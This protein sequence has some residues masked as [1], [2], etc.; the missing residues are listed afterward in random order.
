MET[1]E[2]EFRVILL[3][4]PK[5]ILISF[6]LI[7]SGLLLAFMPGLFIIKNKEM[8]YYYLNNFALEIAVGIVLAGIGIFTLIHD[9]VLFFKE[10]PNNFEKTDDDEVD[11]PTNLDLKKPKKQETIE[12]DYVEDDVKVV[13]S[14]GNVMKIFSTVVCLIVTYIFFRIFFIIPY[15]GAKLFFSPFL[16]I[17]LCTEG[18]VLSKVFGNEKLVNIFSKG[19]MT[20][21]ILYWF[22]VTIAGTIAGI[23]QAESFIYIVFL[24][25]F[26]AIGVFLVYKTYFE[27]DSDF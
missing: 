19:Y 18:L 4:H 21:F 12:Y 9:I 20:I 8:Y 13:K 1:K 22:G 24:I 26:Y 10:P 16:L 27:K 11:K 5:V 7:I 25:P 2:K 3:S 6:A 15:L 14:F 23:K 17:A